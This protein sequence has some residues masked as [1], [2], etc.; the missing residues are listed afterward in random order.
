M[1]ITYYPGCTLTQKSKGFDR[2]AREVARR[3]GIEMEELRDWTC[4]GAA[5]PLVT[6]NIMQ[7]V[8]AARNLTYALR[9]NSNRQLVTL[10][11]FCYNVLKRTNA[12]IRN[13]PEKRDKLNMFIDEGDYNGE[14]QVIHYLEMIRDVVG[15]ERLSREVRFDL[16]KTKMAC[17]YGCLLLRPA[18]EMQL[19]DP[20]HPTLMEQLLE[21]VGCAVVSFPHRTE[22][23]GSYLAVG[24]PESVQRPVER[25]VLSARRSGAQALVTSC[26]L[27]HYNLDKKQR[28]VA[29]AN[30]SYQPLPILYFTEVMGRAFGIDDGLYDYDEHDVDPRP[31]FKDL[32]PVARES[33]A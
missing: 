20:E 9:E 29:A 10:C 17:Y 18:E 28:E 21:A 33:R 12:V 1:K 8:A 19:D 5:F 30:E 15:F 4:C 32:Q 11:A 24:S 23:C 7:L 16:S 25:I 3:L 26:P 6:D 13:D 27:C 22:C 14:V 31:L 2:T